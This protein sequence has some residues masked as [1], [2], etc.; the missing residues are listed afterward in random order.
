MREGEIRVLGGAPVDD[1]LDDDERSDGEI[2]DTPRQCW[3]RR[4]SLSRVALK[5]MMSWER[6]TQDVRQS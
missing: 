5:G 3:A 6:G 1:E 2:A 4:L